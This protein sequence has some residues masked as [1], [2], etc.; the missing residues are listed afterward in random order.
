MKNGPIATVP[1]ST[2]KGHR[3]GSL[4]LLIVIFLLISPPMWSQLQEPQ[5]PQRSGGA[6]SD[7]VTVE[8]FDTGGAM[9]QEPPKALIEL[10]DDSVPLDHSGQA[11]FAVRYSFPEGFYQSLRKDFFYLALP[12]GSPFVIRELDYP[13]GTVE[14]NETKYYGEAT[15]EARIALSES[16]RPGE[17]RL[18]VTAAYQLCDEAGTCYFPQEESLEITV[19]VPEQVS[20]AGAETW[21]EAGSESSGESWTLLLRF[22]LFALIGGVLLNVMP[23]VLPVLSIRA[24][25]LVKQSGNSRG[26]I[27]RGSLFYTLGVLASLLILALVVIALKLSGEMVG[28]GFQFQ[29][30]LFT[31]F[32]IVVIFAFSLSLFDVYV[33]QAPSMNRSLQRASNKGYLGSFFN[34]IIAVLLATPC[35]APLLGSALGFAFSQSPP[36]ILGI[37]GMVGLGFALPFLLIGLRP[38][39]IKKIPKPG[40]WMNTFK[41]LMGFL[42]LATVI[43]LMWILQY[44]IS[45]AEMLSLLIFLLVLAFVLWIYG[46]YAKPTASSGR[47][48]ILL[49][50]SIILLVSAGGRLLR[51]DGDT[52][53]SKTSSMYE[54]WR[55]FSPELLADYRQA[56]EPVLVIFSAKWCTVCK[57]NEESVL[58]TERA[59][60]LFDQHGVQVLYGDYTNED[61]VIGEWIRSYG[62]AGVPVYAYYP[63]EASSHRLLPE[64]LSFR[65]LEDSLG[66]TSF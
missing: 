48:W 64:V 23:C 28:W 33:F 32:L 14:D 24:L 65:V 21:S 44:Q 34:G 9:N 38:G 43:Y 10:A 66:S 5:L 36:V 27:F 26:E 30:P 19:R 39:L 62:R 22:L 3:G 46:K 7:S 18:P 17:Y 8:G 49:L 50:L 37:F 11:G 12:E 63:A 20:P 25:N 2:V 58:K 31:V 29:N 61:P 45:E 56:E 15:L 40:A 54:G 6:D 52:E 51:F 41:E 35:T 4:Q 59:D 57:L 1:I 53:T 55:E 60:R 16:V 47:K 13:S 42:L